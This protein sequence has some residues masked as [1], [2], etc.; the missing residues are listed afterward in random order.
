MA[1]ET[2]A[3]IAAKKTRRVP[4]DSCTLCWAA[5][6]FLLYSLKLIKYRLLE[7]GNPRL[8]RFLG[9]QKTFL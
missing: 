9:N 7:E 1:T 2:L 5:L 8:H 3:T 6:S 4:T